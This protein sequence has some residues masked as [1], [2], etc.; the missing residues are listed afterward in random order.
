MET[1]SDHFHI[2]K[3][4][5]QRNERVTG[6]ETFVASSFGHQKISSVFWD[7]RGGPETLEN[8]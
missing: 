6:M 1:L 4:N 7:I 8:D 5:R 3:G 2:R